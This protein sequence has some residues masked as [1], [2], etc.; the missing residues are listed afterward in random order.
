MDNKTIPV[1]IQL[2]DDLHRKLKS[3]AADEGSTLKDWVIA[4]IS[5]RLKMNKKE[6]L[7]ERF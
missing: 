7:D 6:K 4:A 2:P 5:A 1:Q 3:R